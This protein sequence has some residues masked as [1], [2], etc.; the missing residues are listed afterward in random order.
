MSESIDDNP[1]LSEQPEDNGD[2]EQLRRAL[3]EEA[4]EPDHRRWAYP[5]W[6]IL[7]V[8][9][10]VA[11]HATILFVWNTPAKNLGQGVHRFFNDTFQMKDY[12]TTT[13]STQSWAMFAP[14][15][16]RTN[17]FMR[18]LIEDQN[19][20]LWDA[21]HDIYKRRPYPYIFYSRMGKVNRRVLAGKGYHK[22]YA[23][24]VCREWERTHGGEPAKSVQFVKL[25][26]SI[27]SPGRVIQA[28]GWNIGKMWFDPNQLPLR[29]KELASFDCDR[30]V[31]GQ[32]P[33]RL[34]N[35]YNLPETARRFKNVF[36]RTWWH[37]RNRKDRS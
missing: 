10:F 18:V 6:G 22:N 34:R 26:T 5:W 8:S 17:Q 14:N 23:A 35:R 3:L 15:P 33:P 27:P 9:V 2:L 36:V 37:K 19:G 28:A 20:E 12:L 4:P 31:Q 32:L 21:K 25:W 7:L 24:W 1:S 11:Y 30:T 13:G 29:Q 16:H